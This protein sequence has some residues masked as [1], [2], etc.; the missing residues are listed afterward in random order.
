MKI[1][2]VEKTGK[3]TGTVVRATKA[4]PSKTKRGLS[5]AKDQFL[6]GFNSGRS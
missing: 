4:A 2:L 5:S 1:K 3:L 6:S